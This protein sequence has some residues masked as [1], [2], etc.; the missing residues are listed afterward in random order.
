MS[1]LIGF[2]QLPGK[3]LTGLISSVAMLLISLI[4]QLVYSNLTV[5]KIR[6]LTVLY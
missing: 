1:N 2:W 4:R 6:P 3:L 5:T